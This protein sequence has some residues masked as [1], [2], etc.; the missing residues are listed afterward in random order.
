VADVVGAALEQRDRHRHLQRG[1]HR[2]Q[3][4]VEELVLQ[5]LGAGGDDHLAAREQRRHQV[6][7]GLAGAGA[8]LGH[9]HRLPAMASAMRCAI[10]ICCGRGESRGSAAASGPS[11]A[12]ICTYMFKVRMARQ[13]SGL[14]RRLS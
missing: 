3:V 1:A 11:A 10:S 2:R 6:G 7:E 8:G 4:A 13:S 14:S 9:Q 12:K 5:G